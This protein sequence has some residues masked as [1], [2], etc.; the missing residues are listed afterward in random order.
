MDTP[1]LIEAQMPAIQVHYTSSLDRPS[2]IHIYTGCR[3]LAYEYMTYVFLI[4]LAQYIYIYRKQIL[5][6]DEVYKL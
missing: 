1:S 2:T 3:C 6:S 4:D 5:L